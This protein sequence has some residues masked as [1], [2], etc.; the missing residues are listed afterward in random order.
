MKEDL[1]DDIVKESDPYRPPEKIM[2]RS[3]LASD[4]AKSKT[5]TY[6]PNE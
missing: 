1:I 6:E 4:F 3:D 5:K 2:R